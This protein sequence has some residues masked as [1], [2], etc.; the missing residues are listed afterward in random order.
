MASAALAAISGLA[1]SNDMAKRSAPPLAGI[2]SPK[3]LQLVQVVNCRINCLILP[4]YKLRRL[5]GPETTFQAS[6]NVG[7]FSTWDTIPR[8]SSLISI[9]HCER[10]WTNSHILEIFATPFL[11]VVSPADTG[12]SFITTVAKQ[13]GITKEA[14]INAWK[15]ILI[16][17][18]GRREVPIGNIPLTGD[19][20]MLTA[21]ANL[22]EEH[23]ILAHIPLDV[24]NQKPQISLMIGIERRNEGRKTVGEKGVE[25]KE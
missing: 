1:N 23:P 20:S 12:K 3:K 7:S 17:L 4:N 10:Q 19:T 15:L 22:I 18:E 21:I 24:R 9:C 11:F 14:R 6:D 13:M 8:E 5:I 25:I 16:H 2:V